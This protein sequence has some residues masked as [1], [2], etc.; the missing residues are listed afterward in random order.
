[1]ETS[2][3]IFKAQLFSCTDVCS[4]CV[5]WYL[6]VRFRP[7]CSSWNFLKS[8]FA[9]TSRFLFYPAVTASLKH[10]HLKV[11]NNSSMAI[12][13]VNQLSSELKGFMNWIYSYSFKFPLVNTRCKFGK[14]QA[15][16]SYCRKIVKAAECFKLEIWTSMFKGLKQ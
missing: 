2:R 14:L 9:C 16:F 7:T 13:F 4:H 1:M 10:P 6:V 8:L 5:E 15:P 11:W 12:N 3:N